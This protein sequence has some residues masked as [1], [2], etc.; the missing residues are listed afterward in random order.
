MSKKNNIFRKIF[1]AFCG[2]GKFRAL[3]TSFYCILL[4][5][6]VGGVLLL[7]LG[8][9]PLLAYK[10]LLQGSG[11]LPKIKYPGKNNQLTDFLSLI[12]YTTP[13]IFA[14]LSVTIASKSGL[15]NICVPGMMVLSGFL[16]TVLF[17]YSDLAPAIAKP[18][19]FVIG[20]LS[21]GSLGALIGW[22]K[23]R[24]NMN[25]VIVSIMFN[26]I[27]VYVVSF[28]INTKYCDS[29][30]RQSIKVGQNARFTI[31]SFEALGLKMNISLL[32]PIAIII[33]LSLDF[34]LKKTKFGFELKKVGSNKKASLYSG[35]DVGKIIVKSMFLS[36]ALAGLAGVAYYL[37]CYASIQPKVQPQL[38]FDCIAVSLLGFVTPIG[39][40]FAAFLIEIFQCGAAYLSSKLGVLR[41]ISSLITSILLIF[42]ACALY[43]QDKANQYD[44]MKINRK[45]K[46]E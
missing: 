20:M 23:H 37:G 16:S 24:F 35:I 14:A 9:N 39:C 31:E 29:V 30:S 43:F 18:L 38:G 41:E 1:I 2:P 6:L 19:V 7:I 26:F 11:I 46:Y 25:E 34:M 22:L 36:G 28:F 13:M 12:N 17:G 45:E 8:K 21:G 40:F 15:F 10:S 27:I 32:F 42:S 44:I 5:V 4:S 3:R 33:V